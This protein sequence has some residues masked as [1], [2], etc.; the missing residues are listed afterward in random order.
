MIVPLFSQEKTD[1]DEEELNWFF[2]GAFNAQLQLR[3]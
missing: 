2:S 1:D 3:L